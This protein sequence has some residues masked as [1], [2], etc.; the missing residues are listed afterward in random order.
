MNIEH[1][2]FGRM[3][4][5]RVIIF[6]TTLRDGEQ[7]PGFSMNISEKVRLAEALAE[8]GVDVIEAGF[9]IA[10][11]GDFDSVVAIADA[12]RGPVI[13]GLARSAPGRYPARGRGG[14]PRRAQPHPHLHQHLAAAHE[15][16]IA[17]GAGR[18]AS[19]P[20][21]PRSRWRA[22]TPRTSSGRPRMAAARNMISCAGAPKP[23]SPRGQRR[24]ISQTPWAMR[25]PRKSLRSSPCCA[26]ACRGRRTRGLLRT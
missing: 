3:D 12:V 23:P 22:T 26:R 24:S 17:H 15:A 19:M 10:S 6:D 21:P 16:Q 9:P 14:A 11:P 1:P 7:S 8:L 13:C 2:S 5:S 20:L 25:C 4:E 18:G